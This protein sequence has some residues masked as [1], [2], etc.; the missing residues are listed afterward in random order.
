MCM[1][2]LMGELQYPSP[3]RQIYYWFGGAYAVIRNGNK[4]Q[5]KYMATEAKVKEALANGM[6]SQRPWVNEVLEREREVIRG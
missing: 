2:M 6:K 3:G 1:A 4:T 5:L